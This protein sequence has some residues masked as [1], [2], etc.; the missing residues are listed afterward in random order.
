MENTFKEEIKWL[1]ENSDGV[2]GLRLN[3]KMMDWEEVIS[4]YLPSTTQEL[5]TLS[6]IDIK[7][8]KFIKDIRE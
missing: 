3:G 6:P 8:R 1:I 4:K 7:A 2:V 5:G